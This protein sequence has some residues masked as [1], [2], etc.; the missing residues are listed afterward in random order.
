MDVWKK[1]MDL[2]TQVY[3]TV[4][5]FP[6]AETY[7]LVDQIKRSSVSIPSNIAEWSNRSWQKT[8]TQFLYIS[9][10]SIAELETQLIIAK[11]LWFMKDEELENMIKKIEELNRMISWLIKSINQTTN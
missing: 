9:R 1:S 7:W 2:V 10:W 6:K 11:N 8:Y 5:K 3:K 4:A